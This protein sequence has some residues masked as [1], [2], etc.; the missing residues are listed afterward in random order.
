MCSPAAPP[1]P[2]DPNDVAKA[3][4]AADIK[5]AIANSFMGNAN[6][7]NP[8]GSVTYKQ[9]GWETV[10]EGRKAQKVPTWL[11]TV[12]LSPAEKQ[13]LNQQNQLSTSLN[14]IALD[15]TGKI[16]GLLGSPI[17]RIQPPR[18]G[19][20][21]GGQGVQGSVGAD[22]FSADR[23]RVEEA[24]QSRLNPQLDRDRA[25][26]E[27]RLV[28]QGFQRG[29]DGFTQQMDEFNRQSNDARMQTVLAGGQ[30]QSRLFGMDVSKGNFANA[31]Q[32]QGYD[33]RMSSAAFNNNNRQQEFQEILARRN[34]AIN[35]TTALMS[36]GQVNMPQF[37][38]YQY[39]PVP[40]TPVGEYT[41][42]TAALNNQNYATQTSQNNAAMGGMFGLGSAVLGMFSDRRLKK[43]IVDL[44]VRMKNGAKLYAYEYL[45]E[46][47]RC[48]GVMADEVERIVPDAVFTVSGF[49]A[50]DYAKV[51]V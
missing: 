31:A 44:G 7:R 19:A 4:S 16:G 49:K 11:R 29:T 47:K 24:L 38:P 42:Q 3:Q 6:E 36:G 13:K 23:L 26:L 46:S 21:A 50:V 25:A 27:T 12:T 8:Y 34:Q 41:Y 51:M 22:D 1:P 40:R 28:N 30:E 14:S 9:T 37:A 17:G 5:T 35:E 32:Q 43:N 33:Q 18:V 2:P 10:G 20:V 39:T 15:Q 45:N 48:V